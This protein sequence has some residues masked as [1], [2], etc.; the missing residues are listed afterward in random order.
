MLSENKPDRERQILYDL[1]HMWT[2]NT[3]NENCAAMGCRGVEDIG[4][5][6]VKEYKLPVER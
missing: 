4:Q 2:L 5:M 3:Q 6:L 1:T